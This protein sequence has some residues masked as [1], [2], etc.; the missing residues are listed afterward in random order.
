MEEV[1]DEDSVVGSHVDLEVIVS[2]Q[3]AGIVNHMSSVS[4]VTTRNVLSA[5]PL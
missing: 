1:D 3:T 4:P 2:V 5:G